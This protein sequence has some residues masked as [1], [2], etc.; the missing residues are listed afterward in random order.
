MTEQQP[1]LRVTKQDVLEALGDTDPFRTNA[2]A[3]RAKLGRGGNSTIQKLLEEIR[4]ERTTPAKPVDIEAP[5]PPAPAELISAVWAACWRQSQLQTFARLD[6]A[7]QE[8]SQ[9]KESSTVLKSDHE[10][11]CSDVDDL[12]EALTAQRDENAALVEQLSQVA[13]KHANEVVQLRTKLEEAN[14]ALAAAKLELAQT[15][16]L[17]QRD[18]ELKDL[19]HRNDREHLL[20]QLAELKALLYRGKAGDVV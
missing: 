17:M 5:L 1:T 19:A 10:A 16:E 7:Q 9:L 12:R 4:A 20:N 3:L 6:A 2:G 8:L 13:A 18:S 15:H 11:L 14:A